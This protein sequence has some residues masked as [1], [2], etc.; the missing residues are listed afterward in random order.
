MNQFIDK[1]TIYIGFG[2]WIGP[3]LLYAGKLA[4]HA[5]GFEPDIYA[6]DECK[7]NIELN[8][9]LPITLTK[10]CISNKVETLEMQGIGGSG[11]VV[12]T[13]VTHKRYVRLSK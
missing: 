1:Q 13:K 5:Y 11:S 7:K 8:S 3:M 10:D 2:T 9:E 12:N 6:Y 4:S